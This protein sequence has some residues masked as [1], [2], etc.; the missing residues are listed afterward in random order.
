MQA[1]QVVDLIRGL[2]GSSADMWVCIA[3]GDDVIKGHAGLAG[4]LRFSSDH[5]NPHGTF[6]K[7]VTVGRWFLVKSSES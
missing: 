2:P 4:Q 3:S 5:A 1:S 6:D 7:T